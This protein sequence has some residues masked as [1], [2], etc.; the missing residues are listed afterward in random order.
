MIFFVIERHKTVTP[1]DNGK[2]Q[3]VTFSAMQEIKLIDCALFAQFRI[4]KWNS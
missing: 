4:R 1:V 3:L 2:T